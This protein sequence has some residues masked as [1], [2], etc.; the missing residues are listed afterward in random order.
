MRP[1]QASNYKAISM[2]YVFAVLFRPA[3][4]LGARV[5]IYLGFRNRNAPLRFWWDTQRSS[6]ELRHPGVGQLFPL[7]GPRVALHFF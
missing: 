5:P 4:H 7:G 3:R 6:F 1:G 2:T